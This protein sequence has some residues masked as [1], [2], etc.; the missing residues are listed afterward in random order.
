MLIIRPKKGNIGKIVKNTAESIKQG[1]VIIFPTDTV[2]GLICDATNKK[3]VQELFK[4]KGRKKKKAVPIF[5]KDIAMAK[6]IVVINK[7][8]EKFL[9]KYWPGKVTAVLKTINKRQEIKIYGVD[10]KTIALRVPGYKI[11]DALFEKLN[12]PLTGTSANFSG[13][14]ES[15]KIEDVI[16]QFWGRK[17]QPDLVIDIGNLKKSRPSTIIDLTTHKIKILRQGE[18]KIR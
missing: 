5:V 7:N 17:L 16:G 4:I 15:T 14:P 13:K 9:K 11:I 3:S 1:K 8:Q 18:V 6:K 2:Y 12:R 10:K